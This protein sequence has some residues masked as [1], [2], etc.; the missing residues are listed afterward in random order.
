MA[1][2]ALIDPNVERTLKW[3]AD[4]KKEAFSNKIENKAIPWFR[5]MLGRIVG[6]NI[7]LNTEGSC[8]PNATFQVW[9][10]NPLSN[11]RALATVVSDAAG[12]ISSLTLDN[13][14]PGSGFMLNDA[15]G[16][17][18]VDPSIQADYPL[19]DVGTQ[20]SEST[21]EGDLLTAQD[22]IKMHSAFE[23]DKAEQK[24]IETYTEGDSGN[25]SDGIVLSLQ[26]DYLAQAERAY[27]SRTTHTFP[28]MLAHLSTREKGHGQPT[29]VFLGQAL[30]YF[31][32]LL[33]QGADSKGGEV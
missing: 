8:P 9:V 24:L 23:T 33:K 6:L 13:N 12:S 18:P 4:L 17:T 25:S 21:W 30:D 2:K 31:M 32:L 16:L 11:E 26:I 5:P 19:T 20:V 28:R 22:L 7:P 27:R 29:G 15:C 3:F 14:A 10:T 1:Q